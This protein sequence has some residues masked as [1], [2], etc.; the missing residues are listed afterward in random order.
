V[1]TTREAGRLDKITL[2]DNVRE[3]HVE[4]NQSTLFILGDG[5]A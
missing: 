1:W 5:V 3:S 2:I 4:G